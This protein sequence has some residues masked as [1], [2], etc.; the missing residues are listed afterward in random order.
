MGNA[1]SLAANAVNFVDKYLSQYG[2]PGMKWGRRKNDGP[3]SVRVIEKPGQKLQTKGG[4]RQPASGD[5][6][7][8]AETRQKA[9]RSSTDSLSDAEL[10]ALVNRMNM[11]QQYS[12]LSKQA[13]NTGAK[14]FIKKFL[15]DKGNQNK[16]EGAILPPLK[17]GLGAVS[18]LRRDL[19][20]VKLD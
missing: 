12:N 7:K 5:A 2:V 15:S 10:R 1:N 4:E 14:K 3:T 17:E 19:E 8:H 9:R 13:N 6:K 16:I 18:G 11:E 20:T